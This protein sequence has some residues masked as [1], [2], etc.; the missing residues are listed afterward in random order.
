VRD[1]ELE[2]WLWLNGYLVCA[3]GLLYGRVIAIPL[4][5]VERKTFRLKVRR[6]NDS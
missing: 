1:L 2:I 5:L 4:S 3:S 6:K